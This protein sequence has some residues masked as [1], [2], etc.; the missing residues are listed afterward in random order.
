MA[1][2]KFFRKRMAEWDNVEERDDSV[3]EHRA[4]GSALTLREKI[5]SVFQ[6]GAR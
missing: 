5:L 3:S 4:E 1:L 6:S 2:R